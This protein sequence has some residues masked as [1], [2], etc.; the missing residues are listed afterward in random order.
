MA[1]VGSREFLDQLRRGAD[2]EDVVIREFLAVELLEM[3]V[4][5]PVERALWCGFS[6]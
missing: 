1:T 5:V 6:P 3:L 2:I 4:E